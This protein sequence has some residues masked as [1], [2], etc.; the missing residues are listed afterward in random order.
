M[1]LLV[2]LLS[3]NMRDSDIQVAVKEQIKQYPISTL[4]DIYKSFFQDE[5]GPGHL[6]ND[7][8][9]AREY[10]D[11]EL[12]D[13]TSRGRH[14]AE[15]CGA[16]KNFIRVPMDLVKDG[17]IPADTYFEAFIRSSSGFK[18]PDLMVWRKEWEVIYTEIKATG[19]NLPNMDK[20]SQ[21]ILKMLYHGEASVHHSESYNKAYEPHYR[22]MSK[23]Q[24]E[25]LLK[26]KD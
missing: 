5:F 1:L 15:P 24:W 21:E 23:E 19:I 4:Q 2:T 3:C 6:I 16:G 8:A 25:K 18:T 26:T 22:I 17:V 9:S 20:D 10:F 7:T 11:L 12:E 13:M 14:A